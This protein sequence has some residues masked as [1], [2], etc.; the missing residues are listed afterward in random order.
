MAASSQALNRAGIKV[1]S[2]VPSLAPPTGNSVVVNVND[3]SLFVP[4]NANPREVAAFVA[5]AVRTHL[6][7][8]AIVAGEVA[9]TL[10]MY[11]RS[12][13]GRVR[14][15]PKPT[16]FPRGETDRVI[17]IILDEAGR[18][19]QPEIRSHAIVNSISRQDDFA[20]GVNE[21]ETWG[22][23]RSGLADLKGKLV[24]FRYEGG[25]HPDD[26]RVVMIED[27]VPNNDTY[28]IKGKDLEQDG[29]YR[30]YRMDK[31]SGDI[32]LLN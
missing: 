19:R 5:R 8:G 17:N 23:G 14:M 4:E 11:L 25:S 6:A 16:A 32:F 2:A 3:F 10:A 13:S 18:G 15:I 27:V 22:E 31:I 12:L 21:F 28:L 1:V 9:I 26:F 7:G 20:G 30:S 29:A 24:K